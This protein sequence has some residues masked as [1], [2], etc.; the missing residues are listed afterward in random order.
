M[1]SEKNFALHNAVGVTGLRSIVERGVE[2]C[3][4]SSPKTFETFYVLNGTI[5]QKVTRGPFTIQGIWDRLRK[6]PLLHNAAVSQTSNPNIPAILTG[7]ILYLVKQG[8]CWDFLMKRTAVKSHDTITFE[9]TEGGVYNFHAFYSDLTS[10]HQIKSR[11]L[12]NRQSCEHITIYR[13]F[14]H[15]GCWGLLIFREPGSSPSSRFIWSTS[16][17]SMYIIILCYNLSRT[18]YWMIMND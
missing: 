15:Y 10:N 8:H 13:Y 1:S 9:V 16:T 6:L 4:G 17:D 5:T 11:L 3:R 2:F 14:C 12:R 7:K 18:H